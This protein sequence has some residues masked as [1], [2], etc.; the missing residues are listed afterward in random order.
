MASIDQIRDAVARNLRLKR[1]QR[2][3]TLEGLASASGVSKGMIVEIEQS[4]TNASIATLCQLADALG[5]SVPALVE[6]SET[7]SVRIVRAGESVQLWTGP[8]GG[9]GT[10]LIGSEGE[11]RAELWDWEINPGE[12][13]SAAAHAGGTREL[14]HV[15]KGVLTLHV[16][17]SVYVLKPGDSV[18]FRSDRM[19][20]YENAGAKPLRMAMTVLQP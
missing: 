6:V 14:L 19:H 4:R 20:R 5:T 18:L 15:L 8:S 12:S 13:Y 3:F 16:E 2:G 11:Q 1:M 9:R 7:I 17:S 10:L